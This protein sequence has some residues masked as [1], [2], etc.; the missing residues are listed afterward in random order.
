MPLA[1]AEK[2]HRQGGQARSTDEIPDTA[3]PTNAPE[4]RDC[5]PLPRCAGGCPTRRLYYQKNCF[6]F[7]NAPDKTVL[8]L[9]DRLQKE[10]KRKAKEKKEKP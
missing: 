2:P 7:R 3:L 4:C 5:V 10:N 9:Y 1:H 8:A 6:G